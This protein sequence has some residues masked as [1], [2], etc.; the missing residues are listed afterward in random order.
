MRAIIVGLGG[1]G[2]GWLKDCRENPDVQVVACVEP[3][4]ENRQRAIS[5]RSLSQPAASASSGFRSITQKQNFPPFNLT[6]NAPRNEISGGDV[7]A[8]TTSNRRNSNNRSAHT[9]AKLPKLNA[10]R[11]RLLLP[12]DNDGMR[13]IRMLFQVSRRGKRRDGSS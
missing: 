7:S 10:R 13:M 12:S 9:I 6:N 5:E 1:R 4:A 11:Q 2:R 3:G 8:T